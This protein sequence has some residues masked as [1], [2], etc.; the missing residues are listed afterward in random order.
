M[1]VLVNG[2]PTKEFAVGKGLRQGEP[3]SPFLFVLMTEGLT[4]LVKQSI[5]VGEFESFKIRGC[6]EVDI[7]QFADD[8]LL[9]G[10]GTW[11]H[12]WAVKAVLRAF[13]L[14]SGLRINYH[15]S[16]NPRKEELWKPLLDN[17]KKKLE[18]W[19]Y[20]YLNLGGR[21]TLFKSI[22]GSLMIFTMSFYK[23]PVKAAKEFTRLQRAKKG[24]IW[25]RDLLKIGSKV[26]DDPFASSCTFILR[27]D[28]KTPFWEEKWLSGRILKEDFAAVLEAS[29]LKGISVAGMGGWEDGR[30]KWGDLGVPA[31]FVG[32]LGLEAELAELIVFLATFEG[33]GEGSDAVEWEGNREE[34][35]TV[36]SC[37]GRY[38]SMQTCFGP[39]C[40]FDE[41]KGFVWKAG[42][43]FKI[44][45]FAWRLNANRL[46]TKDLLVLRGIPFSFDNLKCS[47]CGILSEN[48]DHSFFACLL[49]KNLWKEIAMWVGKEGIEEDE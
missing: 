42:V 20:R 10:K 3:L 45:A 40:R 25:W 41:A 32:N 28:F 4:R 24:S 27:N 17:M 23:M 38:A 2:S 16:S 15:K 48:Q 11:K 44:K 26:G 6:C 22:L 18:G 46:P 9:V 39:P 34:G 33:W 14:V 12:V 49:V 5:M 8:T 13:E 19:K 35:F 1:S 31:E 21:I 36:A 37:Y 47:F 30:W 7:I 29:R 43:P